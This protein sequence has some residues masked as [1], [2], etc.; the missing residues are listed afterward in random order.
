MSGPMHDN[1]MLQKMKSLI[2]IF[3]DYSASAQCCSSSCSC[4][5]SSPPWATCTSACSSRS[6]VFFAVGR[7]L[8]NFF[9]QN[10]G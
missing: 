5:R 1:I 6:N 2:L 4:A 8:S 10:D 3:L 9:M 7:E